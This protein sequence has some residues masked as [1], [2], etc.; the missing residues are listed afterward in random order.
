LD[1]AYAVDIAGRAGVVRQRGTLVMDSSNTQDKLTACLDEIELLLLSED[2]YTQ[3]SYIAKLNELYRSA[4]KFD[5]AKFHQLVTTDK[6]LWLGLGTIAEITL[7]S[8]DRNQRFIRAYYDFATECER[9]GFGSVYSQ[10]LLNNF[11]KWIR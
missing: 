11:G 9:L 1:S 10:D 6:F 5:R 4:A 7:S 2:Y 8:E 3:A